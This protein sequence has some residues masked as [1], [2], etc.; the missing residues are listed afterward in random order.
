MNAM[1]PHT[2]TVW[3]RKGESDGREAWGRR[4]LEGVRC[5]FEDGSTRAPGG[6]RASS[7]ASLIVPAPA[8]EGYV[9]PG[10]FSG[11]GWTLRPRDMAAQG[12]VESAEPPKEARAL[13]WARPVRVG[14]GIHHL[15]AG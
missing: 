8:M 4:V 3:C 12:S 15:E 11:A 14:S 10:R 6:D 13:S 5:S 2:V 9:P 7:K 1:Y